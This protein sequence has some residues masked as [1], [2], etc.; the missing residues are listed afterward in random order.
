MSSESRVFTQEE[1]ESAAKEQGWSPDK[2]EL[3]PLE[4]LAKGREFRD[5]LYDDVK[6]L[7]KENSK[8]YDVVAK[9]ITSQEK[10]D[11]VAKQ[12]DL[13]KQIETA[14]EAGDTDKVKELAKQTAQPV[15][16]TVD[17]NIQYINEWTT[18]NTWYASDPAMQADAL[19]FYQAERQKLGRDDPTLILPKVEARIKKEYP[20]FFNASNP[21]REHNSSEKGGKGK[22][23]KTGLTRDDLTEVEALHFDD[24]I[25]TGI[26]EEKLLK[27]IERQRG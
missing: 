8:L 5:R 9:H 12:A 4:F 24:F 26:S 6:E 1:I 10:K 15:Q 11:R 21:N 27:T 16:E 13:E 17:P 3:G 18:K 22:S 25:K 14:V 2:G 23:V 7:R 20:T 19:G